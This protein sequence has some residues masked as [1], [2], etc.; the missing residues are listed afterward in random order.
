MWVLVINFPEGLRHDLH[1]T[2]GAYLADRIFIQTGFSNGLGLEPVPVKMWTKIAFAVLLEVPVIIIRPFAG[3]NR[4]INE[5]VNRRKTK[6]GDEQNEYSVDEYALF[7]LCV[8][9]TETQA[10]DEA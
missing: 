8:D 10:D 3:M 1:D 9:L 4:V 5:C 6:Q 7:A 2:N